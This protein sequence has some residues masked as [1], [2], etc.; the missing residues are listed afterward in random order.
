M[1]SHLNFLAPFH[2][3]ISF[4]TLEGIP[5]VFICKGSVLQC[6]F[7]GHQLNETLSS[8]SFTDFSFYDLICVDGKHKFKVCRSR[9]DRS[10]LENICIALDVRMEGI[11]CSKI[12]ESL[13]HGTLVLK[14]MKDTYFGATQDVLDIFRL[15]GSK[16]LTKSGLDDFAEQFLS[17]STEVF[18]SN[19]LIR[20]ILISNLIEGASECEQLVG[21]LLVDLLAVLLQIQAGPPDEL[22]AL[23]EEMSS[24]SSID[25]TNPDEIVIKLKS[26]KI[27]WNAICLQHEDKAAFLTVGNKLLSVLNTPQSIYSLDGKFLWNNVSRAFPCLIWRSNIACTSGRSFYQVQVL[28]DPPDTQSCKKVSPWLNVGWSRKNNKFSAHVRMRRRMSQAA[29]MYCGSKGV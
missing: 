15:I 5:L 17:C 20:F 4:S 25:M 6:Q 7:N 9:F 29:F 11:S 27:D 23:R 8:L 28:A 14:A 18:G 12:V 22:A 24:S 21:C 1:A 2:G 10:L 26:L 16:R 19:H 13:C 3:R